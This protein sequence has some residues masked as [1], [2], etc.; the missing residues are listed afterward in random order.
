MFTGKGLV[1]FA[2]AAKKNNVHYLYGCAYEILTVARLVEL[3]NSY[4]KYISSSRYDYALK[5]Y[6]NTR[7]TDCS[8]LVY[9]Y[10]KDVK[11]RTSAALW[12]Q[13]AIREKIN[14]NRL[15]EIP[16]GAVLWREGH[17]GIY[18]GNG[19]D[20][21]AQG[22]DTGIVQRNVKNTTFTHYLL[23]N[24]FKYNKPVSGIKI[25]GFGLLCLLIYL[26]AKK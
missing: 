18:I 21:E 15:N 6:I 17:V 12:N 9:G 2:Q 8:G 16:V 26:I 24:D 22:F 7:C 23:F 5:N 19:Q 20:I 3:Y 4:P 13:A 25:A 14:F 11:R 1:E 10:T